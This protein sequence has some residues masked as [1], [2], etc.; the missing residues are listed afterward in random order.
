MFIPANLST[1]YQDAG[2]TSPVTAAGQTVTKIVD[3]S[4]RGN[5]LTLTNVTLGQ[6]DYGYYYL[7]FGGTSTASTAAVNLSSTD[8]VTLFAAVKADLA[9]V[10][11]GIIGFGDPGTQ[12]GTFEL[13]TNG[14]APLLYRRGNT[15]FGGRSIP[16]ISTYTAVLA[17]TLDLA[18][19]T[20]ATENPLL[21]NYGAQGAFSNFG[22]ADS[23]G[24]NFGTYAITVG[25]GAASSQWIGRIYG[26]IVRGATSTAGEIASVNTYLQARCPPE[27]T[28]SHTAASGDFWD[29]STPVAKATYFEVSAFASV[30]YSTTAT[31]VEVDFDDSL[32]SAFGEITV[33]VDDAYYQLL[34][35]QATGAN[36]RALFLPSGTKRV[37]FV[38][39]L[40]VGAGGGASGTYFIGVRANAALTVQTP[41][42]ANVRVYYGDS[43]SVGANAAVPSREGWTMLKRASRAPSRTVV[44]GYGFRALYD[45]A[46][47]AA[48]RTAFVNKIASCFS[49]ATGT[50]E[51]WMAIGTNDYGLNYWTA[52][53]F[54]TAYA[55]LLDALN[56]ALPSLVIYCQTPIQRQ[57][58]TANGLGSTLP[59]Y[60]AQIATAV[61]TRT[62]FCT[63]KD[64][65]TYLTYPTGY[66]D[67]VHPSTAGHA[68]YAAAAV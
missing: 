59:D 44:E 5:T 39:A 61:S 46:I 54:G 28:N 29:T 30:E 43:I 65:T 1:M 41:T 49:G 32:N 53:N 47:D 9:S 68:T 7:L 22:T 37:R 12:N 67:N 10:Q 14:G 24:G 2:M 18:G 66:D 16:T 25:D 19:A 56:A 11:R 50:Q 6:D 57:T 3:G 64:G 51:L 40:R 31:I 42:K 34:E 13:Q 58:E 48:A 20:Q 33:Y 55:A 36:R 27:L 60:R 52:A 8:K 17:A 4:G 15:A 35:R 38:N 63:L 62:S 45:D 23:G 21:Q 26:I